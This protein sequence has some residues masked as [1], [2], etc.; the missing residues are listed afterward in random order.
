MLQNLREH[1]QGWIA[2][3]II[4]ILC[5]AF[6]LLGIQYYLGGDGAGSTMA[7]VNGVKINYQQFDRAYQRYRQ[8]QMQQFGAAA[9]SLS[10]TEQNVIKLSILQQ[11]VQRVL[12]ANS[13]KNS[14]YR[15]DPSQI[16]SLL[17]QIPTFQRNGQFSA[18]LFQNILNNLL[19]TQEEF[20]EDLRQNMLITQVQTAYSN[21]AF[22]LGNEVNT[23][24]A[25]KEQKRNFDYMIIPT[26][27]FLNKQAISNDAIQQYYQS[28]QGEFS[29][30]EQVSIQYVVLSAKQIAEKLTASDQ[31]LQKF[32]LNNLSSFTIP[33]Q[34]QVA[35]IL[36][37]LAENVNSK[38]AQAVKEQADK[39]Y[40]Q[41]NSGANFNQIAQQYSANKTISA[42]KADLGW[43]NK[44][45]LPPILQQVAA[46]LQP[47][48][49][50]A[51]FRTEQG[52]EI[53]KLLAVK[54]AKVR[55]FDQVKSQLKKQYLD[56]KV[57]QIFSDKSDKLTNLSYTNPDTLKV[58][59]ETLGLPIQTSAYFTH[60]GTSQGITANPKI[61]NAAFSNSVLQGNNSDPISLDNGT[62]VVLRVAQH[63][64]ASVLPLAKVIATIK[65]RL[66]LELSHKQAEQMGMDIVKEM[67]K[68]HTPAQ[69]AKQYNLNWHSLM[70]A[71]RQEAGVNADILRKVFNMPAPANKSSISI[72]GTKLTNGDY[73]VIVLKAVIN[74]DISKIPTQEKKVIKG[75]LANA[76][77]ELDYSLY[78]TSKFKS[79]KIKV[80]DNLKNTGVK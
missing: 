33:E 53:V 18:N 61:I 67:Q 28:H 52:F 80:E 10:Q 40:Q 46:S 45:Q 38:A 39:I 78:V 11:M 77:G 15:I 72:D 60:Q 9:A 56:Q 26:A 43:V 2:G 12:L 34:W 7:K 17:L 30:P 20:M 76:Y 71:N 65:Q 49:V 63:K 54:K 35:H 66:S 32:Y 70:G 68:N 16:D 8:Q 6:A 73:A 37:P 44:S 51:P 59:S 36:L 62:L 5:L 58:V 50:S 25:L 74:A 3:I 79:A 13:A 42:K 41:I 75:E 55:P 69:V 48:Q 57:S 23:L 24:A 29:I 22:A 27:K 64:P 21:S 14:G 47:G 19:Y 4:G 1:A 31:D